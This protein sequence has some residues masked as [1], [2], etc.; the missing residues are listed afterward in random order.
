MTGRWFVHKL[1]TDVWC[2]VFKGMA[3]VCRDGRLQ[4]DD[5]VLSDLHACELFSESSHLSNLCFLSSLLLCENCHETLFF[6][7]E[8]TLNG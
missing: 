3:N 6:E 8:F 4:D 2:N 7:L 1:I 5:Y